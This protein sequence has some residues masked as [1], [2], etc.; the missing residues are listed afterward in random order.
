MITHC[1]QKPRSWYN[2]GNVYLQQRQLT[3]A[4]EYFEGALKADPFDEMALS[5]RALA[6][7]LHKNHEGALEDLNTALHLSTAPMLLYNRACVACLAHASCLPGR[8]AR[9]KC[10]VGS[11]SPSLPGP[12]FLSHSLV[13]MLLNRFGEAEDDLTRFLEAGSTGEIDADQLSDA[14]TKRGWCKFKQ[15]SGSNDAKEQALIDFIEAT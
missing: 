3:Q 5:N 11:F 2:G 13:L 7:I 15:D 9:K 12:R 4:L 1:E 6:R 8:A 10:S 14:Q